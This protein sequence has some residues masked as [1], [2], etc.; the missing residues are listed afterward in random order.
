MRYREEDD[1]ESMYYGRLVDVDVTVLEVERLEAGREYLFK[2]NA[3]NSIG[4]ATVECPPVRH[5]I[6]K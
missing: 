6:G 5:I 1:A 4:S 3:S 2:V